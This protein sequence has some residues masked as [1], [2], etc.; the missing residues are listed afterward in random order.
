MQRVSILDKKI[1]VCKLSLITIFETSDE[2]LSDVQFILTVLADVATARKLLGPDK[3]IG[4]SVTYVSEATK[5]VEDGADY[6]GVGAV[7]D[8]STKIP[9]NPP[10]GISGLRKILSYLSSVKTYIPAVA[11]GSV[12]LATARNVM[13]LSAVPGRSLDGIAVVSAI[14]ASADPESTSREMLNMVKEAPYWMSVIN[15]RTPSAILNDIPAL[16]AKVQEEGPLVHQLIN[17]VA[18][19][20]AANVTLAIGA[21][22]VMSENIPEFGDLA[23][24]P[25]SSLLVN[26][27]SAVPESLD[28]YIAAT[29]KYNLQLRPVVLDP[30]GAGFSS[31]RREAVKTLLNRAHFDIIKGNEGEIFTVAGET[32]SMRGVDSTG[33]STIEKKVHIAEG[34]AT[35]ESE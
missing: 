18:I 2:E 27:N 12:N 26:M 16:L 4:I 7:Y 33:N 32:S 17:R 5:A 10:I 29:T 21:S 6:L 34:L 30:V 14:I 19:N 3:I 15:D 22:P 20:F 23:S 1:S 13:H 28:R 9:K 11:I 24:V 8:T 25:S 35:K 31:L